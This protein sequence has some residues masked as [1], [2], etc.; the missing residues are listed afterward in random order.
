[1]EGW[2]SEQGDGDVKDRRRVHHNKGRGGG[3]QSGKS[4]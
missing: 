2:E 1:M 3:G 4:D